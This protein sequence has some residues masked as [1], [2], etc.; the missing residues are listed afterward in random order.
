MSR[1]AGL[2]LVSVATAAA[3]LASG[4]SLLP[5]SHTRTYTARFAR[6]FQLF[7]GVRVTVLGV[8][9]G[10]VTSVR[11]AAGHVDVTFEIT[12]DT[13]K[14]PADARATVLPESLLGE[15][16]LQ[17][18]PTYT[19]GPQLHPG[20]DIPLSRT[21]VPAEG[22]EFLRAVNRYFGHIRSKTL[23]GF[24]ATAAHVLK[25]RGA[26]INHLI[27]YGADLVGILA[28]KRDRLARLVVDLDRITRALATRRQRIGALIDDYNSVGATIAKVRDS[29]E[30]T[31]EGLNRAS[32]ELAALLI[33]HRHPLSRD[34]GALTRTTR[35]LRRN[36]HHLTRTGYY[37]TRLFDTARRAINWKQDWLR[38]G[39][40]GQELVPHLMDNLDQLLLDH[41]THLC[42]TSGAPGCAT[43]R[44]WEIHLPGLFCRHRAC[45]QAA[46]RHGTRRHQSLQAA[47]RR[48]PEQA[49]KALNQGRRRCSETKHP[50]RCRRKRHKQRNNLDDLG[51]LLGGLLGGQ[52]GP[53]PS[54]SPT[55]GSIGGGLP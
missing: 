6:A 32:A 9:V 47:I 18:W 8:P 34:I 54:P 46:A 28:R 12:D 38:L 35:T 39:N 5:G 20:G 40:Q 14:L 51:G 10:R 52:G 25:G 44:Y 24:F 16:Y 17:I 33:A 2:R 19:G 15:R 50:K 49:G 55:A 23:T 30:G 43:D 21:Y 36:I 7:P 1:R 3:L 27:H 45:P 37:A 26:E 22:D 13:V 11:P 41:L 42:A 31:I 48:L 29:I 53:L 4:C